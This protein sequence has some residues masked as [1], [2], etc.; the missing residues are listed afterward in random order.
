MIWESWPAIWLILPLLIGSTAVAEERK[1]GTLESFLCAPGGRRRGFVVKFGV[2]VLLGVF[3][4]AVVPWALEGLGMLAGLPDRNSFHAPIFMDGQLHSMVGWWFVFAACLVLG[5]L[6][7]SSLARSFLQ[8]VG[9]ALLLACFWVAA[10][11]FLQMLG[12][13]PPGGPFSFLIDKT[14]PGISHWQ[15]PLIGWIGWPVLVGTVLA[16]LA[17]NYRELQT[18]ARSLRR[19]GF[20][21]VAAVLFTV[22]AT[23]LIY[24][25]VWEVFMADEPAAQAP[26]AG[27]QGNVPTEL[28]AS[29]QRMAAV[30]PDGKLWLR[31]RRATEE[32]D[33]VGRPRPSF[34]WIEGFAG[35]ADWREVALSDEAG[36]FAIQQ[37]GSLWDMTRVDLEGKNGPAGERLG[38]DRDWK[39]ISVA[40]GHITAL[41]TSGTL[42]QWGYKPASSKS[43]AF[44][45]KRV[46]D[47]IL[48]PA[49]V[50]R[51]AD[52]MAIADAPEMTVAVK[53]DGSVWRFGGI[54]EHDPKSYQWVRTYVDTPEP[55]LSFP[56]PLPASLSLLQ[57][58]HVLAAVG[59]D[60]SLWLGGEI[61]SGIYGEL[62][63][64]SRRR[65]GRATPPAAPGK[66]SGVFL[67][68]S[69]RSERG[70]MARLETGVGWKEFCFRQGGY[71]L[72]NE[73]G[74]TAVKQNGELWDWTGVGIHEPS[75]PPGATRI[76]LQAAKKSRHSD[77]ASAS[78]YDQRAFVALG[79]DGRLCEWRIPE[80]VYF[81]NGQRSDNW[82]APTHLSGRKVAQLTP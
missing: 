29:P 43:S 47:R 10:V 32:K 18:G 49:Q 14:Y 39:T 17:R 65:E 82:L 8:A 71:S 21:L 67:S 25:R 26:L 28:K 56:G 3:L 64:E 51:D 60:G 44:G 69:R 61:K 73:D 41:K 7:A 36:C 58:G 48:A 30:L 50:G 68:E 53:K 19:N 27:F 13:T 22:T 15:G 37:D 76:Q 74:L 23:T 16:L 34:T 77:W 78:S 1:L 9:Q 4:G 72:P 2:A 46:P 79:R 66:I 11:V 20:A 31:Q 80:G 63:P 12:R 33:V 57:N 55:W 38:D 54:P 75:F 52:W 24:H 45:K 62:L 81:W 5:A 6:H 42:W 59:E 70:E 40:G 35:G